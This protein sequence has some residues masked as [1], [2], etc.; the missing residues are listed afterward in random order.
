MFSGTTYT[1]Q[2]NR[3]TRRAVNDAYLA[4]VGEGTVQTEAAARSRR[5][6]ALDNPELKPALEA[7]AAKH[8]EIDAVC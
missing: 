7:I 1:Q 3:L 2:A 8:P 6:T 4:V 5:Q